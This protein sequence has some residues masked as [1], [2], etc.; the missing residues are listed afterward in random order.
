MGKFLTFVRSTLLLAWAFTSG[1]AAVLLLVGYN[2][3]PD[4]LHGREKHRA[5][6]RMTQT[7]TAP[8]GSKLEVVQ[9]VEQEAEMYP[10]HDAFSRATSNA[11]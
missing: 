9:E 7:Q 6:Q 1:W 5:T 2:P 3:H 8:D 4:P 10:A 11:D